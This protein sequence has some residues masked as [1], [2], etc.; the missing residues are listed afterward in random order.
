M[1]TQGW[2]WSEQLQLYLG[3][4]ET[5]LRFFEHSGELVPTPDEAALVAQSAAALVVETAATGQAAAAQE[6]A[7]AAEQALTSEQQHSAKLAAKL[8]E[9]GIDPEVV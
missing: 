2:L 9:L 1:A 5:Q 3:V 6:T 4:H 7:V 8:R